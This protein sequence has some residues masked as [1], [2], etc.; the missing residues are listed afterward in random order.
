MNRAIEAGA[1]EISLAKDYDY[2]Y[3]QG[4]IKVPFKHHWL[5]EVKI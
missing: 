5:I 3:R 4:K 1:K 2:G